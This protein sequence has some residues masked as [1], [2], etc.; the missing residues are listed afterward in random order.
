MSRSTM[1]FKFMSYSF[2]LNLIFLLLEL[3]PYPVRINIFRLLLG[4]LGNAP[5][6]DYGTYFRYPRKIKIGNNV[7]IN[8]GCELYAAY[9]A[10]GGTIT[11]GNNVAL[12]PHVKIFA[13]GHDY[14]TTDLVVTAG[15]VVIKDFVWVGGNTTILPGVL[16][17]EGVVIGAGSVVTQD[18]PPYTVAT[19]NPCRVIKS[20]VLPHQ[21]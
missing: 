18:I 21:K 8:R 3:S 5:L 10:K 2:F 17:G 1:L 12:G 4:K 14:C 15:P 20:R 6:I 7:A 13:G 9:L 16:V 11:I 19:G